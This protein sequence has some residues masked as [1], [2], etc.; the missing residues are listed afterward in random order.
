[1]AS[2][3]EVQ[4]LS[5]A[6]DQVSSDLTN[7]VAAV[8]AEIDQVVADNP[9]IDLSGVTQKVSDLDT[10]VRAVADIKPTVQPEPPAE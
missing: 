2:Q 8:Q 3:A 10:A 4:A 7:S 1:M 9:S 6:V 5:D